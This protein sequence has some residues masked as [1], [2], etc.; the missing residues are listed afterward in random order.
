LRLIREI[1]QKRISRKF[2]ITFILGIAGGLRLTEG[3]V[4]GVPEVG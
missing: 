2:Q 1:L 4:Q 3:T